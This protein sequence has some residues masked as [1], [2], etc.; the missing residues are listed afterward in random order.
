MQRQDEAGEQLMLLH[1][2][3][4][5]DWNIEE[6]AASQKSLMNMNIDRW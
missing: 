4:T 6:F 3:K 5:I 2:Q 1:E